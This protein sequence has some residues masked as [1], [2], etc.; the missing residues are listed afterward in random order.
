LSQILD[1]TG[2]V[3]VAFDQ[4][5]VAALERMAQCVRIARRE[6][7]IVV[8]RLLQITGD[9][10]PDSIEHC[11]HAVL[12]TLRGSRVFIDL[13]FYAKAVAIW[14]TRTAASQARFQPCRL[15]SAGHWGNLPT[16]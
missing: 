15:R 16:L 12:P 3:V 10:P 8:H 14:F 6:R 4:K 11:A 5:H 2:N 1:D 13:H 7:F 9:E